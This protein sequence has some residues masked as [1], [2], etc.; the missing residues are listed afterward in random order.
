MVARCCL[1]EQNAWQP[2][3]VPRM[4]QEAITALEL[5]TRRIDGF[6][7]LIYVFEFLISRS[8]GVA[9]MWGRFLLI[10]SRRN[11]LHDVN[12][13]LIYNLNKE[14]IIDRLPKF[15]YGMSSIS[16]KG[17]CPGNAGFGSVSSLPSSTFPTP[18]YVLKVVFREGDSNCNPRGQHANHPK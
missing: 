12:G 5:E 3:N 8:C 18:P 9:G 17:C 6:S 10:R 1:V 11:S 14:A 2:L 4:T 13:Y 7:L 16:K 15:Q